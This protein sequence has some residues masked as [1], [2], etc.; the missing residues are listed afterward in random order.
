M[1]NCLVRTLSC[2]Y[3]SYMLGIHV[4]LTQLVTLKPQYVSKNVRMYIVCHA[5]I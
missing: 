1:Q 5:F 3:Y 4:A 2:Q